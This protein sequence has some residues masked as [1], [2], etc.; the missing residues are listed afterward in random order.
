MKDSLFGNIRLAKNILWKNPN[1]L[2]AQPSK[3]VGGI[4]HP[5]VSTTPRP[6]CKCL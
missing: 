1:E 2:F 4:R 3:W 5:Q 6:Q